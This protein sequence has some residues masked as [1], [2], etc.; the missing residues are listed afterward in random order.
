[1]AAAAEESALQIQRHVKYWKRCHTS[2]LPAPYLSADSIRLTLACFI[3][4]SLDILNAPITAEERQSIRKWV[5]SLQHPDGGFCGSSTH[6]HDGHQASKG[7]ANLAATYFALV[8]LALAAGDDEQEQARAFDQVKRKKLL[9]WLKKLQSEDG[10]F[11]QVLWDG[12]PAGGNDVRHGYIAAGIRWMLRGDVE[13]GSP[14]W[15]QDFDVDRL[16]EAVRRAQTYDGGIGESSYQHESH[17]GYTYCGVSALAL[18]DRPNNLDEMHNDGLEAKVR[19]A[20]GL[21]KFLSMRQ[22]SYLS[23]QEIEDD[24]ESENYIETEMQNMSLEEESPFVGFNGR[25][26]K[27]ADTCYAWWNGGSLSILDRLS[28]VKAEPSRRYL[29]DITQHIIGGFS[30]N[31]GGPPDV[32]HSYFGLAA[33][34]ILHDSSVKE[35][36]VMLCCA[37]DTTRKIVKARDGLIA[38][39]SASAGAWD[40]GFWDQKK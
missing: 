24:G 11:G 12:A 22:F 10:T 32:Q 37:M 39:E 33:L 28:V 9:L 38:S 40:D 27:K 34:S 30:K 17:G 36:D 20:S 16:R 23:E 29:L 6:A 25:W 3:V 2:Y 15:V 13:Q 31:A 5:L 18:L 14:A 1:M 4:S 8:L 21:L 26:N 19:D 7:T 35:L